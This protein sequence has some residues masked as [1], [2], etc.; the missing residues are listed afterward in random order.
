MKLSLPQHSR[1][2]PSARPS[3]ATRTSTLAQLLEDLRP[4]TCD[5]ALPP[6]AKIFP[7]LAN[8]GDMPP[9]VLDIVLLNLDA[10]SLRAMAS[11]CR[12]MRARA[13]WIAP[14]APAC[15]RTEHNN[16]DGW[17][18]CAVLTRLHHIPQVST[19][20]STAISATRSPGCAQGSGAHVTPLD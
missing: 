13:L 11:T 18:L 16:N 14:G 19:C 12:G 1:T 8:P 9:E 15:P 2:R 4:P 5:A 3:Q 6:V 10:Q 20:P 7:A 17:R